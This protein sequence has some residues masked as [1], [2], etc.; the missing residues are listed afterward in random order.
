MP[1]GFRAGEALR[2]AFGEYL[3]EARLNKP[4]EMSLAGKSAGVRRY[5]RD[6]AEAKETDLAPFYR[7]Q[8]VL[9]PLFGKSGYCEPAIGDHPDFLH[10]KGSDDRV[11]CPITT[12]FV[13]VEGSTRLG[14]L[15]PVEDVFRIKNALIRAA[16]EVIAAFGGHVHRIMGDAVMAYF[17]GTTV[18]PEA[19]A[20]D[21]LNCA[22]LLRALAERVVL[23]K[24][25]EL[26]F[27][28]AFGIR[29]GLDYGPPDK[30]LWCSYGYPRS[31]EVTATSFFVDV[32][33]KL[34][35]AAGR[36]QIMVGDSLKTF[37]DL[38]DDFLAVKQVVQGG[39]TVDDLYVSPNHTAPDGQPIN[40]RKHV[41][42]GD[43][44]LEY[45][46]LGHHDRNLIGADDRAERAALMPVHLEVCSEKMGPC[47]CV[48]PPCSAP[49]PKGKWL[50]FTT[51]LPYLPRLPYTVRCYVENHGEEALRLAGPERGNHGMAH[52]I[53][54]QAQHERFE[55]WETTR[56]RGLHYLTMDVRAHGGNF[57][58]TVAVF[59]E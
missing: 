14:L 21:G 30:V 15:Y 23:P 46:P 12:M 6:F 35:H 4:A 42:L 52:S 32:A 20:V 31:D 57:K 22:A 39:E 26:G 38:H 58:R 19:A 7:M 13:D 8:S 48:C 34:Q 55:H 10:L 50:R 51:R 49:V 44:Y 40:Y 54:T 16:I 11:F 1:I 27:D 33:S 41:F 37:L 24:L 29:I 53:E 2:K 25:A 9:R 59:V 56:Y 43:N 17:G 36:N 45:G 28:H 5:G 18:R 3:E 47:E